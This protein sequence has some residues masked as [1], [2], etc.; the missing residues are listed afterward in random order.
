MS[1]NGTFLVSFNRSTAEEQP[2]EFSKSRWKAAYS[3][4]T[5]VRIINYYKGNREGSSAEER[6]Q[7]TKLCACD[8]NDERNESS[9]GLRRPINPHEAT[10]WRRQ[11]GT[12]HRGQAPDSAS[13][14]S[15]SL[16]REIFFHFV[17]LRVDSLLVDRSS[18]MPVESNLSRRCRPWFPGSLQPETRRIGSSVV[19]TVWSRF[20]RDRA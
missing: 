5:I 9:S 15:V 3:R 16:P 12:D 2:E 6:N 13:P 7:V 18:D 20:T 19:I 17:L 11:T 10:P 4:V 14:C 1:E 8:F